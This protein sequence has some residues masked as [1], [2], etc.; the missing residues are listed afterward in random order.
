MSARSA[1]GT[2]PE[3]SV[4]D[5]YRRVL[6]LARPCALPIAALFLVGLASTP[7]ALLAPLPVAIVVDHVLGERPLGGAVAWLVPGFVRGSSGSVLAWAAALLVAVALLRQLQGVVGALLRTWVGEKLVLDFRARL[8][9]HSQ[10]LSL[11]HHDAQGTADAMYR[12]QYDAPAVQTLA[13][14]GVIPFLTSSLTLGGMLIVLARLDLGFVAVALALSAILFLLTHTYSVRLRPRWRELKR[15]ES[16]GL[17][18][19]QEV[20]TTLRVVKSFG[21]EDRERDRFVRRHREGVAAR[22]KLTAREGGFELTVGLVLALGT[23]AVLVIG[24]REVRAGTLTLGELILVLGYLAQIHEPLRTMSR[25]VTKLQNAL[26]SA[27]RAFTLLDAT[28]EVEESPAARP[29]SR[30]R[31]MVR[32]DGV[33]FGYGREPV[34]HGVSFEV[35]AGARVGIVGPTGVGKTTLVSLLPRFYDPDRGSILLDGVNLREY[36]LADLRNQFG[37]VLQDSILFSATIAENIAYG[38]PNASPREIEDAAARASLDGFVES[39]P[40]GYETMVG[41]RGMSLSGG[42]RQ[43]VALARA[44]LK[45]APILILDEPTSALDLATEAAILADLDRLME[46]RTTF[47]VTHRPSLLRACDQVLELGGRREAPA[48]GD[49]RHG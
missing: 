46:G 38:R 41:E 42:E 3:T 17:S 15:I 36:R 47:L 31:G 11:L 4:R 18:V 32:Y 16:S 6:V 40:E 20:M 37:I 21:Q 26:T 7:L 43:R 29:L 45:D 1:F 9:R 10:R 27:E 25:Q 34:L 2:R 24:A 33:G 28:P 30:S 14:E 35:P 22:L 8:F 49:A 19:V 48:L 13:I 39:L 12:I 44:F 5:L 23:A